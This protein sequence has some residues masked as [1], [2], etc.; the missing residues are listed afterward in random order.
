LYVIERGRAPA[1][2]LLY[3]AISKE[4]QLAYSFFLNPTAKTARYYLASYLAETK[5]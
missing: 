1:K 2:A 3:S 5:E 4:R